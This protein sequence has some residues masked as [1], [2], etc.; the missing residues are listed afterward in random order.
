MMAVLYRHI[1]IK[2]VL[3]NNITSIDDTLLTDCNWCKGWHLSPHFSPYHTKY[4]TIPWFG[5]LLLWETPCWMLNYIYLMYI[6]IYFHKL[7]SLL[8]SWEMNH[9]WPFL[10]FSSFR[11]ERCLAVLRRHYCHGHQLIHRY[12]TPFSHLLSKSCPQCIPI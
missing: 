9:E 5:F 10:F 2:T 1:A 11:E 7:C 3:W 6:F 12:V 4:H 8:I